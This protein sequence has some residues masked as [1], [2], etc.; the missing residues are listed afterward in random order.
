MG[1]SN[2]N[3]TNIEWIKYKK[4]MA[5]RPQH[6][7][8]SKELE[9]ITDEKLVT[10]YE[11]RTGKTIGVNY[12]SKYRIMVVDLAYDGKKYFAY[13]RL[14]PAVDTGAVVIVPMYNGNFV[15]LE[16]FR[17]AL[18]G[19]QYAFPRG[20]ASEG[21][22]AEENC[23][24]ELQEE[25]GCETKEVVFLGTV[26]A[27]SGLSGDKVSVYVCTIDSYEEYQGYEGICS[28]IELTPEEFTN[29]ITKGKINDG[30]SLSAYAM[31]VSRCA[32]ANE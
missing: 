22:S 17:H 20:F 4:L 21:Y 13:E 5:E 25:L 26:V 14:L 12:E 27:D 15:L 32:K 29:Y 19:H 31:Y 2:Q 6:F 10:D 8:S 1:I 28:T 11:N 9:I 16:Q 3:K 24:K 18:R 23:R 7:I 30:Y